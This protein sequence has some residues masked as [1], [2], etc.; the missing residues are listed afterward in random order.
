MR[1]KAKTQRQILKKNNA[2]IKSLTM[3]ITFTIL[4]FLAL[5]LIS[6]QADKKLA[7]EPLQTLP[8]YDENQIY[9]LSGI[10]VKPEFPGGMRKFYE[11][12]AKNY[13]VPDNPELKSGRIFVS[14]VIEKDGSTTDVKLIRDI[15]FG[16]GEEA[17][18]VVKESPK[19]MP[20]QQNGKLVRVVYSLPI[21]ITIPEPVAEPE[22][23]SP[24]KE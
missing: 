21:S 7:D 15:G 2:N 24:K 5:Q 9:N 3:K 1:P 19:W 8:A 23:Q 14:F 6:A 10:E 17:V 16:A 18:R 13:H 20:G 22:T 4:L 12:I 11:Y